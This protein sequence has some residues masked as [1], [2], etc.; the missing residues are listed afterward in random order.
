MTSVYDAFDEL[1]FVDRSAW[2]S[3]LEI[4]HRTSQ[5][6]WLVYYK[7]GSEVPSVTYD[8]AVE[9]ALCFGWIDSRVNG[10]DERRYKQVFTPRKAGSTWSKLNKE[11]VERLA[12]TRLIAAAGWAAIDRAKDDGTWTVLDEVEALVEPDDL[13]AALDANPP[14]RSNWEAYADSVK[15]PALYWVISAKRPETRG[16]RIER[17][18]E[19]AQRNQRPR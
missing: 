15:K 7:T 17:I 12:A 5:G 10:L 19:S 6:I 14:A 11:R 8:E 2:R 4:H 16:R 1:E 9:E 18:V 13:A 3:W